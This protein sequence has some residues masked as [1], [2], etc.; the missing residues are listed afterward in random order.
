MTFRLTKREKIILKRIREERMISRV[1]IA[2]KE[3][4]S[5]PVVTMGVRKLINI[6]AVKEA[7]KE[8]KKRARGG[9]RA[10]LLKFVS[11]FKLTIAVDIGGTKILTA[12]I[13]LDGNIKRTERIN[14]KKGI[15]KNRFKKLLLEAIKNI[16]RD[17]S[18]EKILGIGIGVPGVIESD[19]GVVDFMPVFSLRDVPIKSWVEQEFGISTFCENDASLQ[20]LSESWKGVAKGK[21]NVIVINLGAGIGSGLII[22]GNLYTGSTGRAGEV[23]YLISEYDNRSYQDSFFGELEEKISGVCLEKRLEEFGY[24]ELTVPD[25]FANNQMDKR[26]NDLV[27]DGFKS[28]GISLCNLIAI[29]NPEIIVITGGVGYNQFEYIEK[30]T[31]PTVNKILPKELSNNVIFAKSKFPDEGVLIGAGY[32]IQKKTFL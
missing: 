9:K 30:Y 8:N 14:P 19:K 10:T 5:K 6:G 20:A 27:V 22:D 2:K 32:L 25:I 29:L 24:H 31:V 26:L 7:G 16:T 11:D 18:K 23:G 15:S 17:I 1:K 4:I 28:L 21:K 3:N 13:D 12:L